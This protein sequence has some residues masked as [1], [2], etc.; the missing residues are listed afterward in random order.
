MIIKMFTDEESADVV[1][2]FEDGD[3]QV[4]NTQKRTRTSI[5][6]FHAHRVV[7]NLEAIWS[8]ACRSFWAW[9]TSVSIPGVE[10]EIFRH[11]LH[12]VEKMQEEDLKS[13]TKEI[14]EAANRFAVAN[15]KVEAEASYA[16]STT[17]EVDNMMEHL[18]Y[19]DAMNCALLKEA[20]MMMNFM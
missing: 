9:V 10:P 14:I 16:K 5:V 6:K 11:I 8:N 13:H 3:K 17:I 1:F 19:A 20:V 15:L 7:L 12:Y 18:L 2:E 4:Q